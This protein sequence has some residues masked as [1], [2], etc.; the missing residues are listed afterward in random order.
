M[1]IARAKP[2]DD[3]YDECAGHDLVVV[4]DAPLASALNRRLDRPQFG[5][6]AVTPRRLAAGRREEAEDRLAFLE[7]VSETDLDWKDAA[8]AVGNVLQCWEHQ[9]RPDAVL[10]YPRFDDE[11]HRRAVDHLSGLET[12]SGRLS[13]FVVDGGESVAVVGSGQLTSLERS[14]LPSEHHAVDPFTDEAF[15]RPRFRILDSAA[16]I[17]DTLLEAVTVE[18]A[19]DVAV[20]LEEG[21]EYS[22]LVESAFDA[23]GIPYYGGPG[24]F[25]D[26]DRRCVVRLLRWTHAGRDTRVATVRPLL[27]RLGIDVPVAHDR[28]RLD[29]LDDPALD[30]LFDLRD[31]PRDHTFA[32]ALGAYEDLAGTTL[33]RLRAELAELGI[34]DDPV[35]EAGVDRLR[36]YL[37][38]Y[39]VPVERENEGVL[40][41]DAKSA[42]HVDRPVVLFL[43]LDDGWTRSSPRRPWVDEEREYERN[44]RAFQLLLQSGVDQHYLVRD[45]EGGS[46]VSPC[47]YF[48]E[49]L[50]GEFERFGDLESVRR[51]PPRRTRSDGFETEELDAPADPV[52][53]VSQSSLNAYVNCPRDYFFDRLL[54]SPERDYFREGTLFHDFAECAVH[55]PDAVDDAFLEETV[56]LMLAEVGPFL[57]EAHR[58]VRRTRYRL[59]LE[60]IRGYLAEHPPEG[61]DLVGPGSWSPGNDVADHFDLPVEGAH[62]ER[63]FEDPD[64]GLKGFVDLVHG[65]GRLLDYKSGSRKSAR[66]VVSGSSL[67]P[68][69]GRPNFQALLYLTY[70]R[71][72]RPGERLEFTFLHFLETLDDAVRGDP[73]RSECLTTVTYHPRPFA[74]HAARES[75]FEELR[76][77]APNACTKTF[78]KVEY[79]T[80]REVL[81][82]AGVPA[83]RGKAAFVDSRLRRELT[84]ATKRAVGDYKYVEKGCEQALRHLYRLRA[85]NYFADDL[86][87][88]ESFVDERLAELNRRRAGEERFPVHDLGPEPNERRLSHRDLLLGDR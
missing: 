41:A 61:D 1:P 15:D 22:R 70:L 9:G 5:P 51:S 20:V 64:L 65:P 24:F 34:A 23:E 16:A 52:E 33:G 53:T 59:G 49:L 46:P 7:L 32:S 38:S 79:G 83:V 2:V 35:T 40:L 14:V 3:L 78:S 68:P 66:R 26:P 77:D 37:E 50:D 12:T 87:A 88:F 54:D 74:D 58:D 81:D 60:T 44:L 13:E 36:F 6:F 86:D 63:W 73:D 80:Y 43:G 85:R 39:E 10:E 27:A 76:E 67:D 17:V 42:A 82:A 8:H 56:D 25:D 69:D 55:H 28:K 21:S 11:R 19:A 71:S 48:E 45:T 29:D 47:L 75:V 84:E 72:R 4:P 62:T 31:T 18:N 30:P 57:A